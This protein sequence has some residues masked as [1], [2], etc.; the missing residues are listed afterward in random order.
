M[1]L[2][3]SSGKFILI[4]QSVY[5]TIRDLKIIFLPLNIRLPMELAFMVKQNFQIKLCL[6]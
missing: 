2:E 6:F 4:I 3:V 5:C 1:L